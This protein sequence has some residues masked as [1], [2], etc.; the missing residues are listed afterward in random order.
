M[1]HTFPFC[2]PP[3]CPPHLPYPPPA[4]S[5]PPCLH[6]RLKKPLR[7]AFFTMSP[8]SSRMALMNWKSQMDASAHDT[9]GREWGA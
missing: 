1:A 8:R 9:A 2:F 3:S 4:P 5:C 6:M 7:C